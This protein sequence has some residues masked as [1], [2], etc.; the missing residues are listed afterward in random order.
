[1]KDHTTNPFVG[2]TLRDL[3]L[4]VL[5]AIGS[6]AFE[7]DDRRARDLGWEVTPSHHGLGRSYRDPRFDNLRVCAACD[8]RGCHP[9]GVTCSECTGTGRIALNATD[10][11]QPGG[12]R[13]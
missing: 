11:S 5:R 4:Y 2:N 8:G 3:L 12:G 10:A 13:Q 1:M 6:K 9:S 7:A